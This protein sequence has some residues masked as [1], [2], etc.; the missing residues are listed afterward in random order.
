MGVNMSVNIEAQ[1]LASSLHTKTLLRQLE[2]RIS[3]PVPSDANRPPTALRYEATHMGFRFALHQC[4][5][6]CP[7]QGMTPDPWVT[8]T[9]LSILDDQGREIWRETDSR[10]NVSGLYRLVQRRLTCVGDVFATLVPPPHDES[11]HRTASRREDERGFVAK[12]RRY[13]DSF[14]ARFT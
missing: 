13:R 11:R 3:P 14:V 12:L 9:V 8:R 2:W 4:Q 6:L 7:F 1:L 5:Q 10:M